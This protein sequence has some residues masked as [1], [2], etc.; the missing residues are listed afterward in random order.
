MVGWNMKRLGDM[1]AHTV[2]FVLV[3][4]MAALVSVVFVQVVFRY[5]LQAPPF[6]TEE[7]ARY[8]FI[9]V[10]FLSAA[11]AFHKGEHIVI[12]MFLGSLS[13]PRR[14]FCMAVIDGGIAVFLCFLVSISIRAAA[15]SVHILSPALG[16]SLV[17]V[18]LSL[19]VS[20]GLMILFLVASVVQS[21]TKTRTKGRT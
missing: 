15:R 20:A 10:C 4:I 2:E 5:I 14:R 9:W 13:E 19:P 8:S 7:L 16:I 1:L 17:Y 11:L 21:I 3:I 18:N 6:W 12:D